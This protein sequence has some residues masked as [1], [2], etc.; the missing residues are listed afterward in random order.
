MNIKNQVHI[1]TLQSNNCIGSACAYYGFNYL[2]TAEVN[3]EVVE[4]YKISIDKIM[5]IVNDKTSKV[6]YYYI[7]HSEDFLKLFFNRLTRLNNMLLANLNKSKIRQYGDIFNLNVENFQDSIYKNDIKFTNKMDKLSFDTLMQKNKTKG[8]KGLSQQNLEK[9]KEKINEKINIDINNINSKLFITQKSKTPN[10]HKLSR[11]LFPKNEK[12]KSQEDITQK[13]I[14]NLKRSNSYN[15]FP[16]PKDSTKD[17]TSHIKFFDY[18]ENLEKQKEKEEIRARNGLVLLE[19]KEKK[20]MEK[21]KRQTQTFTNWF[22]LSLGNQRSLIAQ[23]EQKDIEEN[24]YNSFSS[25]NNIFGLYNRDVFRKNRML[26]TSLY[27]NKFSEYFDTKLGAKNFKYDMSRTL[28]SNKK[29]FE[30]SIFD[31]RFT[32]NFRS[33]PKKRNRYKSLRDIKKN[34]NKKNIKAKTIDI[35]NKYNKIQIIPNKSKIKDMKL[36]IK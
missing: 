15:L 31:Q 14:D 25:N 8:G 13:I 21:L 24:G 28:L 12:K 9:E 19:K 2:Y 20:Q 3:S 34:E 26:V 36:F 29:K 27:K 1:M 10:Y 23:Y 11:N 16:I 22:K 7:K 18:R 6:Y 4:L 35:L 33:A 30:Y 32:N 5:R 17:M